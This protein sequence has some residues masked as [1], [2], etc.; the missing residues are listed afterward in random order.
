[1]LDN[2]IHMLMGVLNCFSETRKFTQDWQDNFSSFEMFLVGLDGYTSPLLWLATLIVR[3]AVVTNLHF[4]LDRIEIFGEF[5]R[6]D[7][8]KVVRIW[9]P[10]RKLVQN[11]GA[12]CCQALTGNHDW[13]VV[14]FWLP[15]H[16]GRHITVEMLYEN[17]DEKVFIRLEDIFFRFFGLRNDS[18]LPNEMLSAKFLKEMLTDGTREF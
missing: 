12:G 13:P 15:H 6:L 11:H 5:G 7:R 3:G 1:M 10:S 8:D 18:N 17:F 4:L 14:A 16:L 9:P 2:D